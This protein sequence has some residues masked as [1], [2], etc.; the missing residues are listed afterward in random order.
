MSCALF[1]PCDYV[2]DVD[3]ALSVRN[4][5]MALC[6]SLTMRI[7]PGSLGTFQHISSQH[8]PDGDSLTQSKEDKD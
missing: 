7:L 3:G 5:L 1:Q 4:H 2:L 6:M 8:F